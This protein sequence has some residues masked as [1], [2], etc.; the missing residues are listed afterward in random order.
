M[1]AL[2]SSTPKAFNP[3]LN[4]TMT[5]LKKML[6]RAVLAALT[7]GVVGGLLRAE[8][9]YRNRDNKS[10]TD[11]GEPGYTARI[12][13]GRWIMLAMAWPAAARSGR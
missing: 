10:T 7:F 1:M 4:I 6:P 13:A 8:G 3:S 5:N 11:S 9:P 12:S 2:G